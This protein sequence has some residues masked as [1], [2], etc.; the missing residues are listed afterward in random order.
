M[1]ILQVYFGG[2]KQACTL[3]EYQLLRVLILQAC[4]LAKRCTHPHA[5]C[6]HSRD[7]GKSLTFFQL[8]RILND[9]TIHDSS[10]ADRHGENCPI[11]QW[12]LGFGSVLT[13][14]S[15]LVECTRGFVAFWGLNFDEKNVLRSSCLVL[16]FWRHGPTGLKMGSLWIRLPV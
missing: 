6:L 16:G 15:C 1:C 10:L 13:K 11:T 4:T 7:V 8:S 12:L 9:N 5:I 3:A 14:K 2:S